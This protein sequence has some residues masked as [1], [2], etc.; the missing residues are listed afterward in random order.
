MKPNCEPLIFYGKITLWPISFAVKIFVAKMLT[1]KIVVMVMDGNGEN[2]RRSWKTSRFFFIWQP[3]MQADD[4]GYCG[5]QA[6][7]HIPRIYISKELCKPQPGYQRSYL[8]FIN[9][10]V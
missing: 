5:P 7:I 8:S 3:T 1:A 9:K 2:T 6:L 10:L 4:S